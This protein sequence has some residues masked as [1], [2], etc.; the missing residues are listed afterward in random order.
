M[1][2]LKN[3]SETKQGD[4]LSIK[5][6]YVDVLSG[7]WQVEFW[8]CINVAYQRYEFLKK[9]YDYVELGIMVNDYYF[10]LLKC[11]EYDLHD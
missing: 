11:G 3:F 2:I 5:I 1:S 7:N 10:W 4:A 9:I 8:E 6:M